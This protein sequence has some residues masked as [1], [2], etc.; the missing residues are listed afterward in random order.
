MSTTR[1]RLIE[2]MATSLARKGFAGVGVSEILE[3]ARTPKGVLYHH[4][5]GGK[6]SLAVAAIRASITRITGS[7]ARKRAS[8]ADPVAALE[9][10]LDGMRQ[11]LEA[12][13]FEY[14]C[15]LAATALEAH[16]EQTE[17]RAALSEGFRALQ[18]EVAETIAAAGIAPPRARELAAFFVSAYEGALMQ[19]RVAN[20]GAMLRGVCAMLISLLRAEQSLIVAPNSHP[21]A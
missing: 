5:A 9:A 1:E 21:A 18:A 11:R 16:A 6:T 20:D 3:Q 15:P 7:L 14:G 2:A 8:F 4:F 17:L 13:H 12:S 10:W 19:A